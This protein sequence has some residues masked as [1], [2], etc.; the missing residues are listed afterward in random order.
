MVSSI[1]ESTKTTPK[2]RLSVMT[3]DEILSDHHAYAAPVI[4]GVARA[5]ETINLVAPPKVGKSW[6]IM[7]LAISVAAEMPWLGH[8][9][10]S[11][12]VLIIDNELDLGLIS[13]RLRQVAHAKG[14]RQRDY[15]SRVHICALRGGQI[16]DI[17]QLTQRITEDYSTRFK[18]IILDAWYKFIPP[19][20]QENDNVAMAHA[21]ASV[22][23]LAAEMDA[24]VLMVHHTCKGSQSGKSTTDVGSGAGS[25]SRA[26]DTHMVLR[27]HKNTGYY[28]L[29]AVTRSWPEFT[30]K[31]LQKALPL[32]LVDKSLDSNE[33]SGCRSKVRTEIK[34]PVKAELQYDDF[35]RLF[36]DSEPR[37]REAI[38]GL[39]ES[40]ST[41]SATSKSRINELFKRALTDID[42]S[43]SRAGGHN[44]PQLLSVT[45]SGF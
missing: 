39:I 38:R 35:K 18:L 19:G 36:L 44:T 5:G 1:A 12:E 37:S 9:V 24:A 45:F 27:P 28:V 8:A 23:R 2:V 42:V 31:V 40:H 11:G 7:D 30:P 25:Q 21:Y 17:H 34:K 29:D 6:L 10:N 33:L 14:V 26:A 4:H 15:G 32:W 13:N 41:W 43:V 16:P 3:A 22:S 20:V